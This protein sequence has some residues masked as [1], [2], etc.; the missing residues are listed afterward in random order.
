MFFY[1]VSENA[2]FEKVWSI[3]L[4]IKIEKIQI[5]LTICLHG[6][7]SFVGGAHRDLTQISL[8]AAKRLCSTTQKRKCV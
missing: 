1:K 4:E 3:F 7:S 8:V 6:I 2:N 5:F